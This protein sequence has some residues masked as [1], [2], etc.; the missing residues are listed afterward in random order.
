M[1]SCCC[2]C[3]GATVLTYD[4]CSPIVVRRIVYRHIARV[5]H[6]LYVFYARFHLYCRLAV[7]I[8]LSIMSARTPSVSQYHAG[9]TPWRMLPRH[10]PIS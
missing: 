1:H 5:R 7:E 10:A 8:A 2:S 6:K 9:N 4:N 3:S